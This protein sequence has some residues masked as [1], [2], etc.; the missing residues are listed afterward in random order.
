MVKP[1]EAVVVAKVAR[2]VVAAGEVLEVEEVLAQLVRL[3]GSCH[4][5]RTQRS[6]K[7]LRRSLIMRLPMANLIKSKPLKV[8]RVAMIQTSA[9]NRCPVMTRASHFLTI[10]LAKRQSGQWRLSGKRWTGIR[11]GSLIGR[12]LET[13]AGRHDPLVDDLAGAGPSNGVRHVFKERTLIF[14]SNPPHPWCAEAFR[15]GGLKIHSPPSFPG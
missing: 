9:S 6:K 3:S 11:Q 12:H 2:F 7:S 15:Q 10:Y 13:H 14:A 8:E 1:A 5:R 4:L